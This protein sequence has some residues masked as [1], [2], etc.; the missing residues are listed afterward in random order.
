MLSIN[1]SHDREY[2]VHLT[3]FSSWMICLEHNDARYEKPNWKIHL[4]GTAHA[5]N[6]FTVLDSDWLAER[7]QQMWNVFAINEKLVIQE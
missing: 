7:Q 5:Q 2:V 6:T 1:R 3:V 4:R